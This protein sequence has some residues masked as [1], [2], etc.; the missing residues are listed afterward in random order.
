MK[1]LEADDFYATGTPRKDRAD[2][3][4]RAEYA[5]EDVVAVYRELRARRARSQKV[6]NSKKL[7]EVITHLIKKELGPNSKRCDL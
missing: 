5:I 1:A 7:R 4:S 6:V 2:L 3:L